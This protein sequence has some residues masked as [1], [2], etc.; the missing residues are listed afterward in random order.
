MQAI[1]KR[2]ERLEIELE[3]R[4]EPEPQPKP[5]PTPEDW[6]AGIVR[7]DRALY[8]LRAGWIGMQFSDQAEKWLNI[9]T[10]N[11]GVFPFQIWPVST[12]CPRDWGTWE[13][14]SHLSAELEHSIRE[15]FEHAE[16]GPWPITIPEVIT[17]LEARRVEMTEKAATNDNE[18]TH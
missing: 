3:A 9:S 12:V 13:E 7:I 16:E 18:K 1:N 14:M 15:W 17:F 2:L 11:V 4:Q 8:A 5:E 6:A 10:G